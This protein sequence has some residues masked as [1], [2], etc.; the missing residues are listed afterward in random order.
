MRESIAFGGGLEEGA[1]RLVVVADTHGKPHPRSAELISKERPD[2]ILHA[3]DIGDMSVLETLATIAPVS[4]VRGNIDGHGAD[5]PDV[6]ILDICDGDAVLLKL[7]LLHIAV[8][9]PRLRADAVRL[10]QA[11]DASVVVCGHSHVPFLGRDRGLVMFNPGSIGPRR[12]QLPILFGVIHI[13]R[14]RVEMKHIDC[15]SGAVWRPGAT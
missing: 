8:N 10:A 6:R 12:F 11:E 4:A 13:N 5:I 3:G 1:L 2:R 15:E 7:L 9:G 14:H